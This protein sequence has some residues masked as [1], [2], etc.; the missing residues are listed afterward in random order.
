MI[1]NYNTLT[2]LHNPLLVAVSILLLIFC[3][4]GFLREAIAAQKTSQQKDIKGHWG[5]EPGNGPSSWGKL[6]RDWV[7]CAEGNQQSPI[8]LTDARQEKFDEMQLEYPTANL[9]I[10]HQTHVLDAIDNGHTIQINYDRGE[11]F[12]IGNESY[13]LRQY[14]FHSPSEHTVNGRHYPMEMHLVHLSKDK[15]IA[16]IGV[17]IEEG[18]HNAAF[19][20]IWSNLPKKTGQQVHLENVQVDIDEILPKNKA[21][22]RYS[23]SLTTP[24]CSEGV[25]WF[26]YVEPVQ[27]SGDQ[28]KA[29]QKIFHGNNRP[30]QPLNDRTLKYDAVG[31]IIK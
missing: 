4:T 25:R 24:P 2:K 17:F 20:T 10:V 21:T 31:E 30:I 9:T 1:R 7:L 8:D 27:L 5:Y 14:H 6:N 29:F 16:V 28:I 23:G 19:D 26:V 15:K 18:R 3:S 11:T 22:Y 13:K 12:T